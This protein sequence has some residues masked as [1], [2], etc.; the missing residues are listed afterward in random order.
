MRRAKTGQCIQLCGLWCQALHH[1]SLIRLNPVV[2]AF[3]RF[4]KH[5]IGLSLPHNRHPIDASSANVKLSYRIIFFERYD[6]LDVSS[7]FSN[8][9][10]NIF[11]N[12]VSQTNKCYANQNPHLLFTHRSL[13]CSLRLSTGDKQKLLWVI[14]DCKSLNTNTG[15]I[16]EDR[17]S[18]PASAFNHEASDRLLS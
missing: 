12:N 5:Y 10:I 13:P 8:H 15:G 17:M 18:K 2:R 9:L 16:S 4:L 1:I 6:D 7:V 3:P 11:C 14:L